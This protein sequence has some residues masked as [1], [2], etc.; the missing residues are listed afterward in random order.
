MLF[1]SKFLNYIFKL[2]YIYYINF[3]IN[4]LYMTKLYDNLIINKL[5]LIKEIYIIKMFG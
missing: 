3:F 5:F 2:Y 1:I 4:I